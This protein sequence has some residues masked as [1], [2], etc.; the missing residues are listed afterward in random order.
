MVSHDLKS[1]NLKCISQ[2]ISSCMLNHSY[3]RGKGV[4]FCCMRASSNELGDDSSHTEP[5][6]RPV[7]R[8]LI[9]SRFVQK[10]VSCDG[11]QYT[12]VRHLRTISSD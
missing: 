5:L 6:H 4:P 12:A 9:W 3:Q 1:N 2:Y 10:M 8:H 7:L 11:I